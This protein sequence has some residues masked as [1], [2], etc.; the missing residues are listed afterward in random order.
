MDINKDDYSQQR[1]KIL[2]DSFVSMDI[3]YT[4]YFDNEDNILGIRPTPKDIFSQ[5]T[6]QI[7][8]FMRVIDKMG[9]RMIRTDD[10]K[11]IIKNVFKSGEF[12]DGN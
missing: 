11:F 12:N 9:F 1:L 5:C 4:L 7:K 3:D 6:A 10:F 8:E 2:N